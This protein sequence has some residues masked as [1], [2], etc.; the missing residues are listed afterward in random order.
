[1]RDPS[2]VLPKPALESYTMVL[3]NAPVDRYNLDQILSAPLFEGHEDTRLD[4]YETTFFG[5]RLGA[6]KNDAELTI[7]V[8]YSS[9]GEA[10]RNP[11]K[12]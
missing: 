11:G 7:I 1:M 10:M 9:H 8:A 4:Q 12:F 6:F 2:L 5:A 3:Q